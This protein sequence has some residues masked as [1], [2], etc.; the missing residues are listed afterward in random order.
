MIKQSSIEDLKTR[1]D[2]VDVVGSYIELKKAGANYKARCPFHEEKSASFVVSP[3]KQIYHCFGCGAGGDSISFVKEVEKLNYPEAIEKLAREY[4]VHLEYE[5]GTQ[6]S[7]E[8]KTLPHL[9][10]LFV[11]RLKS[12][13]TAM[14]YLEERGIFHS[15]IEKFEIGY[16]PSNQEQLAFFE[17]N[18]IKTDDAMESGIL[19]KDEGGRYYARFIERITFPIYSGNG[20]LVGFGGRT[21]SNHPAKYINS[22]QTKFFNKSRLLYAYHLAK[23]NIYRKKEIIVTEGYI[24]VVMLHQAG[25]SNVVATLG[26]AL[27]ADHLPLLKKGDPKVILAYDGDKAGM[28]AALKAARMLAQSGFEGGVA[29]FEGGKDPAD[30]VKEARFDYL[31]NLFTHPKKFV[32]FII[33]TVASG[34]NLNVPEQKET[35]VTELKTFLLTLS[36]IMQEHY[37]PLAAS[38]LK[39]S[40]GLFKVGKSYPKTRSHA[41]T[42]DMAEISILKTLL[43]HPGLIDFV[44]DLCDESIFEHHRDIFLDILRDNRESKQLIELDLNDKINIVTEEELKQK[45]TMLKIKQMEKELLQIKN[46]S[47]INYEEKK[48]KIMESQRMIQDLKK[49]LRG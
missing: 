32:D 3:A 10:T 11:K 28:A 2:I 4:S 17:Q 34:F 41:H 43:V 14:H 40:E 46:S 5:Q 23:E 30:F 24:D 47:N 18:F 39:C 42:Y 35:A 37:I 27:T 9:N 16:A 26:T 44:L 22:P 25:F 21:I 33:D 8:N 15:T 12:N 20:V 13:E 38:T 49:S 6:R 31:K 7:E 45:I 48:R 36:P 29:L 19:A 1:L